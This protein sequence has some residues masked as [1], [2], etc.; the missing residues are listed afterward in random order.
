MAAELKVSGRMTV[1]RLKENFKNE[2]EGTL[3]VYNGREKADDNATLASIRRNND[4]KGGE[5]VCNG[6]LT[7]GSFEKKML[8]VFGIKVQV[9]T[10]D[11]WMLALDG[12]TLAKLK[13]IPEKTSKADME[14]LVAYKRKTKATDEVVEN[15]VDDSLDNN[16][17]LS[18]ISKK[19]AIFLSFTQNED[20]EFY[21]YLHNI[22]K[23]GALYYVGENLGEIACSAVENYDASEYDCCSENIEDEYADVESLAEQ[24]VNDFVEARYDECEQD[25]GAMAIDDEYTITIFVGDNKVYEQSVCKSVESGNGWTDFDDDEKKSTEPFEIYSPLDDLGRCGV[26]YANICKQLMPTEERGDIG[27]IKPS[28]WQSVKYDHVDGKYLYNRSHLIGFQL[29][30]ENDNKLNLIKGTR[31]FNVTGM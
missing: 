16:I 7:V 1:K 14:S 24:L 22:I 4:A 21:C 9:A 23:D 11:D 17:E 26:A 19:A 8:E 10:P 28:G 25:N 18:D 27:H 20:D 30:G 5:L 29:A 6:N 31:Y 12:I 15:D 13:D 3:R 2:F